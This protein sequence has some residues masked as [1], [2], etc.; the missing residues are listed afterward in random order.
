MSFGLPRLPFVCDL[1]GFDFC[2]QSLGYPGEQEGVQF[3]YGAELTAD[4]V[5]A[6]FDRIARPPAGV[7]I[8]RSTLFKSVCRD[9]LGARLQTS[10]SPVVPYLTQNSSVAADSQFNLLARGFAPLT[11]SSRRPLSRPGDRL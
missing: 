9:Y 1:A 5:K 8:S 11:S 3:H 6:T 10:R 2:A 7:S 4:D